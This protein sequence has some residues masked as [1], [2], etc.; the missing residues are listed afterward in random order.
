MERLVGQTYTDRFRSSLIALISIFLR[1]ILTFGAHVTLESVDW[2]EFGG[3][4][5]SGPVPACVSL[6]WGT[7]TKRTKP[8]PA[9]ETLLGDVLLMRALFQQSH[10]AACR[11][12][13]VLELYAAKANEL[14]WGEG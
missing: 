9:S 14:V 1:P 13:R 8:A 4:M 5:D 6:R 2:T 3:V 7:R 11:H 12:V 10:G